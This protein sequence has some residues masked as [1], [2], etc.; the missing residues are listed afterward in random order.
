MDTQGVGASAGMKSGVCGGVCISRASG[1]KSL[2]PNRATESLMDSVL[3]NAAEVGLHHVFPHPQATNQ[4][5]N[6]IQKLDP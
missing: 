1:R 5:L 2:C 6:R 3:W 4:S